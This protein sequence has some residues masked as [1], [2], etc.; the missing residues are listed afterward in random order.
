MALLDRLTFW[1]KSDVSDGYGVFVDALRRMMSTKAGVSVTREKALGVAT[2]LACGRVLADGI[3]QVPWRVMR[4]QASAV[5]RYPERLEADEHSYHDVLKT[6]PNGWQSSFEFRETLTFHVLFGRYGA[7]AY[8]N[9]VRVMGQD[10][11]EL[12]LLDP[13]RVEPEQA[14]DWS[15][16]YKVRGKDGT[17]QTLRQDQVWHIRGPSWDGFRSM[18]L[19]QLAR[20]AIGLASVL[21]DS[22]ARM[23]V[24]GV[25]PSDTYSVDGTLSE[26]QQ[27]QLT[28]WIKL[29]AAA[30][31]IGNPLILDRSA[32]L[33]ARGWSSADAQLLES[34][35]YQVE[36]ICRAFRVMPI[37]IGYSDKTATFASAEAMFLAHKVHTL[38]PWYRRIQQSADVQ[39]LTRAD[40]RAGYYTH[41][42]P[43]GLL[44]GDLRATAEHLTRLTLGGIMVRNE[45]RAKLELNPLEG[46]DEPLTP[47]NMTNDPSG[48]PAG[49][50]TDE[51][52]QS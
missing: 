1:R 50:K 41:L 35:R 51:G 8:K 12:I 17:T 20:E 15:I 34:R 38:T 13:A 16:T 43:S 44:M 46:L 18:D 27:K 24:N 42:D 28:A 45:A 52:V 5:S 33:I 22:Q 48:A 3:A 47:T 7:F 10:H 19:I 6:Q 2:V 9:T 25:K 26:T 37:M 21:E 31:N 36:E 39:L 40:R 29:Q 11:H 4:K 49:N 14:P 23:H 30:D 32:K